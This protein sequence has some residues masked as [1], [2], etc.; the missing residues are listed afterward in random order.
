MLSCSS[1]A[2]GTWE[3]DLGRLAYLMVGVAPAGGLTS[4]ARRKSNVGMRTASQ[5]PGRP[6]GRDRKNGQG[7]A[8]TGIDRSAVP[9]SAPPAG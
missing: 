3:A 4:S 2:A 8:A 6:N 1:G 9:R 7:M 5:Q